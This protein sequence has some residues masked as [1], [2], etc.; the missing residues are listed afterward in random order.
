MES[1]IN[2]TSKL[3]FEQVNY[4]KYNVKRTSRMEQVKNLK[5]MWSENKYNS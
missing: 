2:R 5:V 3:F 4:N 1:H